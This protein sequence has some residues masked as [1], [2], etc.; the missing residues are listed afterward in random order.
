MKKFEKLISLWPFAILIF[1]SLLAIAPFFNF[2]FFPMHDDTQVQRVFEMKKSLTDGMFPVR[3]VADLGYGYGYPIFNFYSPLP[4][5]IGAFISFLGADALLATKLMIVA[6]I[7][8]SS[9]SMYLFAKEFWGKVGGLFSAV[10]YLFAPYH[11]LN[12][13]VRGDVGELYAYFFIPLIF[14]GIW[15]YLQKEDFKFILIGALSFA[16]VIVSHNLSALMIAPFVL[17]TVLIAFFI[18]RKFTL[19]AI[20]LLGILI[21]SFYFIPALLE[22]GYTNIASIVGKNANYKDHFVCLPQLWDSIWM[23]GGSIPGCI[24]GLSFRIGKIHILISTFSFALALLLLK[25]DKQKFFIILFSTIFLLVSVFFLLDIS[26]FLWEKIP[27]M[28]YFQYP[29]RFLLMVSFF[30]S[31]IGGSALYFLSKI[32]SDSKYRLMLFFMFAFIVLIPIIYYSK[33]FSPQEYVNKTASDYT[34]RE[35]LIWDT[36]KISDEYM[37]KNFKKPNLYD[38]LIK[39]KITGEN[40]KVNNVYSKTQKL[41]AEIETEKEGL[42]NVHIPYFP[43]WKYYVNTKSVEATEV[44]EGVTIPVSAGENNLVAKFEQTPIERSAN[45]LSLSGVVLIIAG[46]IYSKKRKKHEKIKR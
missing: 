22:M 40:I 7:V 2:G 24:D 31:F 29:W 44:G 17:V 1:S 3:W 28:N 14:Y 39:S 35:Y 41:S 20:P 23:Y 19:F 9:F 42:I 26:N 34:N 12:T 21:S 38:A 18:K 11:A 45:L 6:S 15:K 37:P 43:A 4:Y 10:L 32:I 13:Y 46:I 25:K 27:F 16:G 33:I 36:S 5:Y 8:G 30:S